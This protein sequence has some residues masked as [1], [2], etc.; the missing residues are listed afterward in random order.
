MKLLSTEQQKELQALLHELDAEDCVPS[1]LKG[2]VTFWALEL[3]PKRVRKKLDNPV[4][5]V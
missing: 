5:V 1:Q 4:E 3:K 2:L